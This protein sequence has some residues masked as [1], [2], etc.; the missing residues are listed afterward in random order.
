MEDNQKKTTYDKV[1]EVV[2][3]AALL[4]AFYPLLFYSSIDSNASFPT[5][6]NLAGEVDGWGGRSSLWNL[7]LIGLVFYIGLSILQKYPGI[8]NFPCEVTEKNVNYLY[9]MGVQLIRSVK[10]LLIC[11]FAYGSNDIYAGATGKAFAHSSLV[12]VL[13][14]IGLFLLIVIYTVKMVR[15]NPKQ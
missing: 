6:Y 12:V 9:R 10:V 5:H 2:A 13:F 7:P 8:Y 11:I 1:L 3:I 15:Y 14:V 4:W